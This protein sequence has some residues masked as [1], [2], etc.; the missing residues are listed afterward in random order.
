MK[1]SLTAGLDKSKMSVEQLLS[2]ARR[3]S[4]AIN[5][6]IEEQR[7]IIDGVNTDLGKMERKLQGMKP[8]AGQ[9]ELLV[10]ISACKK[11]LAEEIT[12]LNQLEQE[13]KEAQQGVSRLEQEYK[14]IAISEEQAAVQS[15]SLTAR[16]SE[17]KE[18]VRQVEA[19]VRT[20]QKAYEKAIP[21]SSQR[22]ALSELNAA[23]R[24][25]EEEKAILSSLTDEQEKNKESNRKLSMQLRELQNTMTRMRLEGRQNSDEYRRLA[26]EAAALADTLAD[27]KRQTSILSDDDANLQGFISG[28]NGLSGAFTAATGAISLFASEN[29]N[30]MK[31]QA[32]VQSVMAI[33]MGLQQMFNALNKDSAFRLVTVAKA[34][35]L[36]TT[37]N[38][39]L[40]AALGISNAAASALMATLT[41]GLSVV[42]TGLVMAWNKFSD[43]QEEARRKTQELVEVESQ[44]RAEMLKTRF[45]IDTTRESLK[46]FNGTQE[47]EKQKCE[48]L[49]RKYGEAFGYYDTIAQWYDVLTAK[50]E[51]Y[52][53]MLFLQSKAQA[54][55]NKAIEA[56]DRLNKIKA[57]DAD[58]V[59]GSMNWFQKAMMYIAQGE[60]AQINAASVIANHNKAAKEQAIAAAKAEVDDYLKQAEEL[61]KQAAEVAK[62][63][64]IGGHTAPVKPK[65]D[66]KRKASELSALQQKTSRSRQTS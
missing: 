49:N 55:V 50:A 44:G 26:E 23:K 52:I 16:I 8:G 43:A 39:R 18:V 37:A 35:N 47:E 11:V 42:I 1:D 53:K 54:M 13:H 17:Q 21:G 57:T 6:K 38:Y 4:T 36:L 7:R 34:K 51:Q 10:E 3:A 25:L 2:V 32:R 5:S 20:L 12:V 65:T 24:A 45:E 60:G 28:V 46:N 62:G 19:D 33:T 66:E 64:N 48:E 27:V 9:K 30:L 61:T 63:A 14:K 40:A 56:D 41:L 22:E 59:D 29:E 31:I 58:D 15:K